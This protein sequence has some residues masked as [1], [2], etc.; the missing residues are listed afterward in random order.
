M[1]SPQELAQRWLRQWQ[2]ADY[3]EQRLLEADSWPIS[4]P[5]GR[6]LP[7]QF[8]RH[9]DQ[10]REHVARWRAVTTGKVVWETIPYRSGGMPVEMPVRWL[11]RTPSEWVEACADRSM[12]QDYG[13]LARLVAS[14]DPLFR[15][16]LIRQQQLLRD[17]PD[18]EIVK[19]TEVAL[20]L[21]PGCAR[22]RPLRALSVCGIDSKF[23][24]RHRGLLIRLLDIRFEGQVSE[25]GIE[26]FLS[27]LDE[28]AHWLLVAPL[29]PKLLPFAQQRVRAS[30]LCT[31]GLPGS[32]VLIVENERALHQLPAL[33]DTVAVLGAGL[34]L[35]WM[36]AN[37]LAQL[38]IGYWG[39]VDTWGL[40]MLGQ[41][42][43]FQTHLTPLLMTR[44]I[45]DAYAG[46][47]AVAEPQ[48]AQGQCPCHLTEDE[49]RLY[50]FLRDVPKGRL[51]QEFLPAEIVLE[52]LKKWRRST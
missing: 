50:G 4:L 7:A 51:E 2:S 42:R 18:P 46:A 10:V 26:A 16:A 6:P 39:D 22:G 23:F 9:T 44:D 36:R 14:V 35:E 20:V 1:K 38:R 13:R 31:N 30:E 17:E 49:S 5:I 33:A 40:A 41:A 19:A 11:V 27:A 48:P 25:L 37:W 15:R 21:E 3:R 12:A 45:F 28:G 8:E 29:A 52:A 43:G 32:H 47:C 24:E 34:N